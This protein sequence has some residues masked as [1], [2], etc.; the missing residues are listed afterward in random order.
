MLSDKQFIR[1]A[2][3]IGQS[4][5]CERLH[6]GAVLTIDRRIISTGYNGAPAGMLHCYHAPLDDRPC[7]R[8]VHA[9]ANAIA[10]A[11]R[12]GVST[13]GAVLYT[14]HSP[15]VTCAR[16]IINAGIMEVIYEQVYRD[17][18]GINE[19]KAVG[20][21]TGQNIGPILPTVSTERGDGESL[22]PG[23]PSDEGIKTAGTADPDI[24]SG[25]GTG[26]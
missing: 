18:R 25:R 5:T 19:L 4:G 10:F 7:E 16:L 3:I 15:C 12:N 11:A 21:R 17:V 13:G 9:E 23:Q 24:D 26:V 1:I 20:I 14:T 8:T 2:G 6:V 22:H